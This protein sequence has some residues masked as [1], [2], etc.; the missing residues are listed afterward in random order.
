MRNRALKTKQLKT[1]IVYDRFV[2][3]MERFIVAIAVVSKMCACVSYS[4]SQSNVLTLQR[5]IFRENS[6]GQNQ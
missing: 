3:D 2:H 1:H 4:N 6:G 5:A